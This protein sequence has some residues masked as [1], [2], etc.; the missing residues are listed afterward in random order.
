MERW[1]KHNFGCVSCQVTY[2]DLG[3]YRIICVRNRLQIKL[4][5]ITLTLFRCPK[6]NAPHL[7]KGFKVPKA[8]LKL[9]REKRQRRIEQLRTMH[10]GKK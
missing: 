7:T 5:R 10:G 1:F 8:Q 9:L 4:E 3:K 2:E 6:C